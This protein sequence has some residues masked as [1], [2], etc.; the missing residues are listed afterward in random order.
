VSAFC[1]K[2]R[3]PL[4]AFLGIVVATFLA[5]APAEAAVT[6]WVDQ[7]NP[8]CSDLGPGTSAAPFCTIKPGGTQ[9]L[10]GD[11]VLVQPGTYRE[12]VTPPTSGAPGSPITYQAAG[13][14]VLILGTLDLSDPLGWS[15]TATMAWSQPFAP[16]SA[17]KQVFVDGARLALAPSATETTPNSFFYDTLAKVLYVDLGGSNPADGHAVEAGA[18]TYGF[19]LVSRSDIVID[20]FEVKAPNSI[21]VRM[22]SCTAITVRHMTVSYDAATGILSDT[23]T[24]PLTIEMNDLSRSGSVGIRLLNS[25]GVTVSGN[26]SHDNG[27]HGIGL[28]G[29]SNNQI[30]GNTCYNNS[31]PNVRSANGIDVNGAS[32]DNL[33]QGNT[34]FNN[35][36]SGI[37][38]YNGSNRCLVVRNVSWGNG[39][40]GFDTNQST[41]TRYV[42][43]TSTNNYKDGF[44][45]EGS[46]VN[47]T[48]TDNIAV[49]NGLTTNEFDLYVDPLST[50][51]FSSDYDLFW[52]SAPGTAVKFNGVL[53]PTLFDYQ[54]LTGGEVHGLG[55]DPRFVDAAAGNLHIGA[56]SPAVDSADAGASGFAAADHDGLLPVDDPFTADTGAGSPTYADRG[57]YELDTP[58]EAAPV[59]ALFVTPASGAAPLGVT[60][61]ASGSTDGDW[62]PIATYTFDF[63]DGTVVGPQSG[64][65]ATH[66]Y[67]LFGNYTVT[68]TVTDTA[69]LSSTA[70]APVTVRDAPPVARLIVTPTSG[71]APLTVT[72]DAS[73]ST[74][75]DGTPVATYRFNFGDGTAVGPQAGATT[76]HIYKK[77]GAVKLTVTV[78]D[79]AG[80]SSTAT[81]MVQVKKK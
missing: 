59:A 12:Q 10:P 19:N 2:P 72:A 68:V 27:F 46:S 18:R 3:L 65:T 50:T 60:A 41:D 54:G 48:L 14:G 29:S 52:N 9:A 6:W 5:A 77:V 11:T 33:V 67:P 79:T 51:G 44:S 24:G 73:G 47:T 13:P 40:H 64:A 71:K 49:D 81:V 37:Q 7:N 35:Q 22:F 25:T 34:T 8:S 32:T 31:K 38:V 70:T 26:I 57:A 28:S 56:G 69:G 36:D 55:A 4:S 23:G 62:T 17:P 58:P 39:D 16:P 80:L 61:N 63:G 20:G 21:G 1:R 53:Y 76:T 15:P 66:T 43:N 78:T 30:V 45:V 75:S 74:D 42:S